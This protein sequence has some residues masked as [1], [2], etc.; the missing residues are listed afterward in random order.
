ML[1]LKRVHEA[2]SKNGPWSKLV[3]IEESIG[4]KGDLC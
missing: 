1:L 4:I 3:T 2:K